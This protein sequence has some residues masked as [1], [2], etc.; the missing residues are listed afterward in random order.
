M[1]PDNLFEYSNFW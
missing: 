1:T